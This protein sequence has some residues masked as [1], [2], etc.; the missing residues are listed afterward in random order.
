ML[1]SCDLLLLIT[2][3]LKERDKREEKKING[4]SDKAEGERG[5]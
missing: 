4:Y 5:E 3:E 2:D 1:E